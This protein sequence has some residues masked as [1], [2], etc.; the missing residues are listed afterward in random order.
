MT[1]QRFAF[2]R[3]VIPAVPASLLPLGIHIRIRLYPLNQNLLKPYANGITGNRMVVIQ[4]PH[5][6]EDIELEDG[7]TGLFDCPYCNNDFNWDGGLQTNDLKVQFLV[8]LF[9]LF[10]PSVSFIA[11]LL[12]MFTVGDP[13]ASY[14]SVFYFVISIVICLFC[15]TILAII[16]VLKKNKPL[17]QGIGL[18]LLVSILTIFMVGYHSL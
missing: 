6:Q 10:S 2:C 13:S 5:C 4:C 7:E 11:S 1:N 14:N 16:S 12:I 15:T 8:F 17:S 3:R 9:S 18:S